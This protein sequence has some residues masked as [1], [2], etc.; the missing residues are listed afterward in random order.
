MMGPNVS[1]RESGKMSTDTVVR[2][3]PHCVLPFI[4]GVLYTLTLVTPEFF[5]FILQHG[6]V[7]MV[8]RSLLQN[9]AT[10]QL[11]SSRVVCPAPIRLLSGSSGHSYEIT[12]SPMELALRQTPGG[13]AAIR[14]LEQLRQLGSWR[15][16]RLA[17]HEA[18]SSDAEAALVSAFRSS[19]KNNGEETLPHDR[20]WSF[21]EQ[22]ISQRNGTSSAAVI[23]ADLAA[24]IITIGLAVDLIS[25]LGNML[26]RMRDEQ[27]AARRTCHTHGRNPIHDQVQHA[28]KRGL[29]DL[30]LPVAT[31]RRRWSRRQFGYAM[32]ADAEPREDALKSLRER[33]IQLALT[34]AHDARGEA[35]AP[36]CAQLNPDDAPLVLDALI[37]T[38]LLRETLPALF[39]RLSFCAPPILE[40]CA[41]CRARG[42]SLRHFVLQARSR[43]AAGMMK[44]LR[45]TR[46]CVGY[47]LRSRPMCRSAG[48][49][50][51]MNLRW[52]GAHWWKGRHM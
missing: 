44:R 35:T 23:S 41:M 8:R 40:L 19:A 13:G 38:L 27:M 26:R 17:K 47:R 20:Y 31:D 11:L 18:A 2:Q 39:M 12:D 48:C 50:A 36:E 3:T 14:A 42:E 25:E 6:S 51:A 46:G 33:S 22:A 10:R 52:R 4:G 24:P 16:R 7:P 45:Y 1:G 37:G 43:L 9:A 5:Y 29:H 32:E 15:T 30:E 49:G 21:R 28:V 34:I